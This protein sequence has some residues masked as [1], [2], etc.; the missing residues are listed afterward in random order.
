LAGS[1]PSIPTTILVTGSPSNAVHLLLGQIRRY[2]RVDGLGG[3]FHPL[4]E[5]HWLT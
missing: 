3:H 5:G 4:A 2:V 1:E